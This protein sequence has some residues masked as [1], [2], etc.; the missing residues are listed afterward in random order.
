MI[1]GKSQRT[2]TDVDLQSSPKSWG[3]RRTAID[4]ASCEYKQRS[5]GIRIFLGMSRILKSG[6][7]QSILQQ[8]MLKTASGADE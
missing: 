5:C 6:H 4:R 3:S 7:V 2:G 8:S 1:N